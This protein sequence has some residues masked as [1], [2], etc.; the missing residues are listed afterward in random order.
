M[1]VPPNDP[2]LG[3]I[4]LS[5]V[6]ALRAERVSSDDIQLTLTSKETEDAKELC[7]QFFDWILNLDNLEQLQTINFQE[8][9]PVYPSTEAEVK[10][11]DVGK[12]TTWLDHFLNG[13]TLEDI[14]V[15]AHVDM[16]IVLL[17]LVEAIWKE[18]NRRNVSI[19]PLLQLAEVDCSIAKHVYNFVTLGGRNDE[20]TPFC[21]FYKLFVSPLTAAV[22]LLLA[23]AELSAWYLKV[24][25]ENVRLFEYSAA[26]Y[27]EALESLDRDLA[28]HFSTNPTLDPS[29]IDARLEEIA[30]MGRE[31]EALTKVTEPEYESWVKESAAMLEDITNMRAELGQVATRHARIA[32]E[33]WPDNLS[34]SPP[35]T[36]EENNKMSEEIIDLARQAEQIHI[37]KPAITLKIGELANFNPGVTVLARREPKDS[38]PFEKANVVAVRTFGST[39]ILE[40]ISDRVK[41]EVGI[42]DMAYFQLKTTDDF[43]E[44]M[45]VCAKIRHPNP[46]KQQYPG[47]GYFSG[48]ISNRPSSVHNYEYLPVERGIIDKRKAGSLVRNSNKKREFLNLYFNAYPDWGLV[49]LRKS[50]AQQNTRIAVR[51][52][53]GAQWSAI[54]M[55][56]DRHMCLL[57]FPPLGK[58]V[59]SGATCV[60]RNCTSHYHLDERLYRGSDRFHQVEQGLKQLELGQTAVS[61][62]TSGRSRH[63]R[64]MLE[65]AVPL[66]TL[67]DRPR[68]NDARKTRHPNTV[69]KTSA[70]T[71]MVPAVQKSHQ[72]ASEYTAEQLAERKRNMNKFDVV[73][74]TNELSTVASHEGSYHMTCSSACLK[75]LN[76]DSSNFKGVSPFHIPLLCGWQRLVYKAAQPTVG[77]RRGR[78]PLVLYRGPCGCPLSSL[79][80]VADYLNITMCELTIDL[81]AFEPNLR[82]NVIIKVEARDQ[83]LADFTQGLEAMPITVVN[84]VDSGPLP[85]IQYSAK[86]FPEN[87]EVDLSSARK[88]FC[89]GCSC[90]DDCRDASKCECQILTKTNVE[91]MARDF[92]PSEKCRGYDFRR[93]NERVPSGIY[94]CNDA[95][96]CWRKRCFNRV[97]QQQI[98]V[99]LQLFKTAQCGWGV[100][101]LVD[102]PNGYFVSNYNGALLTDHMADNLKDRGDEYFA[103]LDLVDVIENQK[104]DG[105]IDLLEDKGMADLEDDSESSDGAGREFRRIDGLQTTASQ[106]QPKGFGDTWDMEEYFGEKY[107]FVVDAK[108]RGNIGRFFNHCCD[109]NVRAQHVFIDTHDIR[110]PWLAI[111]TRGFIKAGEELRW[112]YGYQFDET[113]QPV[114]I[115]C[116]C[117]AK[118]CRRRLL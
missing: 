78:R 102:L 57:R 77:G 32:E 90:T 53:D 12:T 76:K 106:Q 10:L 24:D 54:V 26:E 7:D 64:S 48:T 104:R 33:T 85:D 113:T 101:T 15:I 71:G 19:E 6:N 105:G 4:K 5:D 8:S 1:N 28:V 115:V 39:Y 30:A 29:C 13:K 83:V 44:G 67:E 74:L 52:R 84:S 35:R 75:N 114:K 70:P 50:D 110:L 86:R 11:F 60:V 89:T 100:R 103:E 49:R 68:G 62:L 79:N 66:Y 22:A 23:R 55:D 37:P 65:S 87:D 80:E 117:G 73:T 40:F 98:K 43:V 111:F 96:S 56:I 72:F 51:N 42:E 82:T 116:H 91:R 34:R 38:M 3:D 45:R 108:K 25:W 94:E 20:K 112:D 97:A 95:C 47:D 21:L 107:L 59:G 16:K 46:P 99:P 69:R 27:K 81:F 109:P 61:N 2:N 14:E 92:R 93:A 31:F 58:S 17:G 88:E 9:T 118:D 41:K 18:E 36:Q 63:Q